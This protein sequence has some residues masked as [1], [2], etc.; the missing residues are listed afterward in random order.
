MLNFSTAVEEIDQAL[1]IKYN[2]IV[3][4][5]K[6][7]GKNII[8]LSLGEAFFDIP[9]FPIDIFPQEKI[10]HYTH[11]RGILEL[12]KAIG[13]Y[14]KRR[15]HVDVNPE[16]EIVMSIGAKA[17]IHFSLMSVLNAGDE[18]IVQEP[19]W[20]SYPAMIRLCGGKPVLIPYERSLKDYEKYITDKT[21]VIII[22]NPHNPSGRVFSKKE[23]E[24]LLDLSKRNGI[25]LL[26][27]EAYSDFTI[28]DD[29]FVSVGTLDKNKENIII[30]NSISKNFGISGWRIGYVI[31][32]EKLMDQ[33]LKIHQHLVTCPPSVLQYYVS[34]YFED[35]ISIT[36]PQI[37]AVVEKRNHVSQF[38]NDIGLT[39]LPGSSTFYMFVSISPSKLGSDEFC[40][41]LLYEKH[42]CVVPGI[43][44]GDSCDKFIRVA[45]GTE[46][47]E[48]VEHAMK[49]IKDFIEQTA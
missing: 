11:S 16:K 38:V 24:Y 21:K 39:Q 31:G 40:T 25:F 49:T 20:V 36:Y 30:C 6:Q 10:Y 37:K 32:S 23:L 5:L 42:I 2:N 27:D 12:R 28:N 47:M 7:Q 33:V 22:N 13:A 26:S 44:Y 17:A 8:T 43:G 19:M 34:H 46:S 29:E 35:I 1:S 48:N 4:E 41:R 3:Y 14:Y 18:V 45:V 9:V 15:F